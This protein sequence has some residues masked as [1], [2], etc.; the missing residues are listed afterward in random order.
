MRSVALVAAL[1]ALATS[2]RADEPH[3]PSIAMQ[4][5]AQAAS[6]ARA[7][8]Q[9]AAKVDERAASRARRARIAYKLLRTAGAPLAVAPA[10]RL[11]I[12][13]GRATARLLLARDRAE[14]GLLGDELVSLDVAQARIAVDG[15]RAGEPPA[16]L[17]LR[18]PVAGAIVRRFGPFA[19]DRSHATLSRRGLDFEVANQ[20]PVV[21]PAGG[22]VRYAGPIR[23]L[24]EGVVMDCGDVW[25]VVAKLAAPEVATG[26]YV[27][28]G[29]LLGH[30]QRVRV[31]LE[32]R[33]P[34]GPGGLPV[35]PAPYLVHP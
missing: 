18:R 34:I 1:A 23:G 17:R 15:R 32:V 16:E 19:H 22:I 29:Q 27:E 6:I 20:A 21:A 8:G 2:A 3:G 31:Y 26:D 4:L 11:A 33:V 10:E 7:R 9:V 13:R 25:T 5:E 35:D 14:V 30:A 24:D 12:A 28:A